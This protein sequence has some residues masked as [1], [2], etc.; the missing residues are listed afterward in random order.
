VAHGNNPIGKHYLNSCQEQHSTQSTY[1]SGI[2]HVMEGDEVEKRAKKCLKIPYL[3]VR[4][5]L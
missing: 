4:I 3:N 5:A 2:T 1:S